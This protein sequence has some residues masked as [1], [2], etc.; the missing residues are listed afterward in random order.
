MFTKESDVILK[1]GAV[2]AIHQVPCQ[3]TLIS[4]PNL[5][6]LFRSLRAERRVIVLL[7]RLIKE[8]TNVPNQD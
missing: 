8:A 7:G 4:P 5:T 2:R 3:S 1:A 6:I